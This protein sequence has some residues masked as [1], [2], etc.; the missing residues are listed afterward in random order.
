MRRG[1][2]GPRGN[3]FPYVERIL[4]G[5]RSGRGHRAEVALARGQLG[6]RHGVHH[7]RCLPRRRSRIPR[8]LCARSCPPAAAALRRAREAGRAETAYE[9]CLPADPRHMQIMR[10]LFHRPR[11]P[12]GAAR[13]RTG[14]ENWEQRDTSRARTLSSGLRCCQSSQ[15]HLSQGFE[16]DTGEQPHDPRDGR[17][18]RRVRPR[19][20]RDPIISPRLPRM[21]CRQHRAWRS[22]RPTGSRPRRGCLSASDLLSCCAARC[23]ADPGAVRVGRT[24]VWGWPCW[25]SAPW[26]Y[27]GRWGRSDHKRT[28]RNSTVII[29][30]ARH[31]PSGTRALA[32]SS[33][34]LGILP[35]LALPSNPAAGRLPILV[36]VASVAAMD[37]FASMVGW[38]A[39]RQVWAT[40]RAARSYSGW[41]RRRIVVG[42]RLAFAG[43]CSVVPLE[44]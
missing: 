28:P 10:R 40:A 43:A 15:Q 34:L 6:L 2:A 5:A 41:L 8:D 9:R 25:P 30:A 18:R 42:G 7:S 23:V 3:D 1:E 12:P 22:T 29:T 19:F 38:V 27:V 14:A 20:C 26:G 31:S 36:R 39:G 21:R 13:R 17:T 44:S 37:T 16:F 33:H 11:K 35:V 4:P 24:P 32:G